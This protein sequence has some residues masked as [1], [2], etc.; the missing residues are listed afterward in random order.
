MEAEMTNA[1]PLLKR[2]SEEISLEILESMLVKITFLLLIMTELLSKTLLMTSIR[3]SD[4]GP[5]NTAQSLVSSKS[6][7]KL[8][9]L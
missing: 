4:S 2:A 6:Q 9:R 8:D 7:T 5:I 3:I 1:P